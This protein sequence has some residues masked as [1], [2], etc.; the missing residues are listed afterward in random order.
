MKQCEEADFGHD[1]QSK[2]FFSHWK[3][4]DGS[5]KPIF[6]PDFNKTDLLLFNEFLTDKSKS[7]V[8]DLSKCDR[9]SQPN[10]CA[11]EEEISS[12]LDS[13]AV[14]LYTLESYVD[15]RFD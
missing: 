5:V 8:F 7:I 12:M 9:D 14:Q 1:E 4:D 13:M 11:A 2:E 3:K 6:C 15:L 10:Y